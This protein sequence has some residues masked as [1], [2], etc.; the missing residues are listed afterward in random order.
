MPT[1]M[2]VY[3][4]FW[5]QVLPFA[6]PRGAAAVLA[7]LKAALG[8]MA[9]RAGMP[10]LWGKRQDLTPKVRERR[11][12]GECRRRSAVPAAAAWRRGGACAGEGRIAAHADAL[13]N[14]Q[15]RREA[16]WAAAADSHNGPQAAAEVGGIV[17]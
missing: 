7:D 17:S 11:R 14:R 10:F 2:R 6:S 1:Q 4:G 5:G 15:G 9:W 13:R 3:F 12:C 8:W 16:C